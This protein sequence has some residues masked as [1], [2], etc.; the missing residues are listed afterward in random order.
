VEYRRDLEKKF[1]ENFF[2][3]IFGKI[4]KNKNASIGR[5]AHRAGY[6]NN[7]ETVED[8]DRFYK[9]SVKQAQVAF[10]MML[11]PFVIELMGLLQA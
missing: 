7:A 4:I 3:E 2:F 8:Q 11:I 6:G 5:V 10:V 9:V 1:P